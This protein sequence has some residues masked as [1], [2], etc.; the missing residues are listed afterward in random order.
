MLN[1]TS[2]TLI[3][4]AVLGA[5]SVLTLGLSAEELKMKGERMEL[6][7]EVPRLKVAEYHRPYVAIWIQNEKQDAVVNLAVWYQVEAKGKEVGNKWL[8]DLRQW[9]RRTG[10][11]LEFPIDAVSGPTRPAGEHTLTFGPERFAKL[12]PGKHALMVEAVR[13]VGGRELLELPFDWPVVQTAKH[14]ATGKKELGT[15]TLLLKP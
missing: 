12:L 2:W 4:A 5:P 10:R 1:N 15:V 6:T 13:E 7:V 14:Q 3:A 8:P 9:W 11:G